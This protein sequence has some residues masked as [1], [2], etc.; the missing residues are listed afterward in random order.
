LL[1]GHIND[2][3]RQLLARIREMRDA[4]GEGNEEQEGEENEEGA[5]ESTDGFVIVVAFR[6]GADA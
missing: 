1:G 5:A 2:F 4:D 6:W 3:L